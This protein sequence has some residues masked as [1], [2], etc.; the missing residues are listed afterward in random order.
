M[1]VEIGKSLRSQ[2]ENRL[3]R[4][5]L[6]TLGLHNVNR[7]IVQSQ[8]SLS[9]LAVSNGNGVLL[10][11]EISEM[12]KKKTTLIKFCLPY[13]QRFAQKASLVQWTSQRHTF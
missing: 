6:H 4:L 1:D 11:Q 9:I 12:F 3:D 7:L 10:K 2:K 5:N 8:D 13:G